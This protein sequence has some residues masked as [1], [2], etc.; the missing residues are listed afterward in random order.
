MR[1]M[2]LTFGD[3]LGGYDSILSRL[4][5]SDGRLCDSI[6]RTRR[7]LDRLGGIRD[8]GWVR[9][10]RHCAGRAYVARSGVDAFGRWKVV[11][12]LVE[13]SGAMAMTR[14]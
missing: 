10:V 5:L 1:T 14:S 4:G 3:T 9:L 12:Y 7:L 6:C 11:K 8:S 13:V 2:A